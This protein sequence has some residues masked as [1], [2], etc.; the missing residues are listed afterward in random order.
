MNPETPYTLALSHNEMVALI[1]Y[2]TAQVWAVPKKVGAISLK[3][4][5]ELFPRKRDLKSLHDEANAVITYHSARTR[6][7][8]SLCDSV[9]KR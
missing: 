3:M 1:K 4:S 9:K 7:I 2:H 6:G 8:L 5:A